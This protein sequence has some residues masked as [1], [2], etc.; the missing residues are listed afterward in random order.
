[1]GQIWFWAGSG[2]EC[3]LDPARNR[4][5]PARSGAAVTVRLS[6]GGRAWGRAR[7]AGVRGTARYLMLGPV[8]ALGDDGD[9]LD[10]G[11]GH[12]RAI[13]AQLALVPGRIVSMGALIDGLWG[14]EPPVTATKSI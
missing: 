11:G 2:R 13:L 3:R 12:R 5:M 9:P 10:I 1:M 4:V 7:G 14:D 6:T 8:V